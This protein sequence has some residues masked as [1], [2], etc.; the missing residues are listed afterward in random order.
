MQRGVEAE[1]S[2]CVTVAPEFVKQH[3]PDA[4][5]DVLVHPLAREEEG[6]DHRPCIQGRG[7]A[8]PLLEISAPSHRSAGA[9]H[10]I[11][12]GLLISHLSSAEITPS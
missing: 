4:A 10:S 2:L 5:D 11:K 3:L 12:P 9:Q 7:L 1:F 8:Q 6:G